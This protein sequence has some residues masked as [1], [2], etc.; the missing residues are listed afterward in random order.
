[1][2]NTKTVTVQI[3]N[4]GNS[5]DKLTQ[6]E[7]SAFVS[8]IEDIV[9]AYHGFI[10]FCAGSDSRLPWQNF[11]WVFEIEDDDILCDALKEQFTR[12][13]IKFRQDSLVWTEGSRQFI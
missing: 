12:T 10:H 8:A 5:D 13:R 2:K 9:R 3:G 6:K 1:M 11:C 4:I 7:W